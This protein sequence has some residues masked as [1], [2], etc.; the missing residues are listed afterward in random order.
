MT[1]Y[2]GEKFDG[3][4]KNCKYFVP[5]QRII[6]TFANDFPQ[7]CIQRGCMEH[8]VRQNR[9]NYDLHCSTSVLPCA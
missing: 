2:F 6:R 5:K 4:L 7:T 8:M 3:M 1:K 9:A